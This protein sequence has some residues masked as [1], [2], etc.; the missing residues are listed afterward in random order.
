MANTA[1]SRRAAILA[2][3]EVLREPFT[4]AGQQVEIRSITGADRIVIA[5]RSVDE[6]GRSMVIRSY[7]DLIIAA[8]YDP[9]S[10]EKI[11]EPADR[12]A[13][14]QL[15]A[16]RLEKAAQI[17]LRLAGLTEEAAEKAGKDSAPTQNTAS[18]STSQSGS[19][20][21]IES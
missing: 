7:P 11:F 3:N 9:E 12:E 16:H 5:E 8:T 6:Q 19:A 4:W 21:P 14:M 10:D 15:P 17:A 1:A 13:L 20:E 2:S 18:A